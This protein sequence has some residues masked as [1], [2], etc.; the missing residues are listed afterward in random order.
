MTCYVHFSAH[1]CVECWWPV[2]VWSKLSAVY[3]YGIYNIKVMLRDS[4]TH[5]LPSVVVPVKKDYSVCLL[6]LHGLKY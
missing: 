6:C 1:N 4:L 3:D 5:A 2:V